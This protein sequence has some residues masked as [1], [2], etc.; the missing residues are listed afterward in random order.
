MKQYRYN[1]LDIV[2]FDN[3]IWIKIIRNG[4]ILFSTKDG[5]TCYDYGVKFLNRYNKIY[6]N[7]ARN[8]FIEM[9]TYSLLTHG[10][11]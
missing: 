5:K 8:D 9:I 11:R 1:G 2:E 10:V 4:A 3:L 7:R 6:H